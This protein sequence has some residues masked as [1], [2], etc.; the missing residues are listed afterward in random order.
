MAAMVFPTIAPEG[1]TP[2][3]KADGPDEAEDRACLRNHY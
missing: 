1:G 3:G 2:T